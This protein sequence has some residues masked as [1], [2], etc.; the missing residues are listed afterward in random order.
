MHRCLILLFVALLPLLSGCGG[1]GYYWQSA[2]GHLSLMSQRKPIADLLASGRLSEKRERQL[3]QALAIRRFA[4]EQLGL[5]DNGSYKSFVELGRPY[6][7]WNVVAAPRYSLT[8]L[9]WCFPIVGCVSYRGYYHERDARA[10][11]ATIDPN[12]FDIMVGG[13][14][15]YSTL[16]WFDDPLTSPMVDRGEILLAEVVF[17]ELAHQ[18]LYF[19][20]DTAFNEA[21]ASTVGE[22]GVRR[23]LRQTRPDALPRYE[24]WLK[25]KNQFVALLNET[26]AKLRRLY[27]SKVDEASMARRKQSIFDDLRRRYETLRDEQWN[28]YKGYDGWFREPPNN[29]RLASIA[30]YRDRIPDFSRWL[31]ACDGD[32]ERF[33]AVIKSFRPLTIEQRARRLSGPASCPSPT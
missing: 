11:A 31:D 5:P 16:G 27:A 8:P 28:G 19:R 1:I 20:N 29:A 23:W 25:R 15:A 22:Q 9:R 6:V 4:V 18:V 26:A 2:R 12:K 30:V 13:S 10:F 17:H 21:F 7:V 24:T 14:R 32:F 3:R 33:Y